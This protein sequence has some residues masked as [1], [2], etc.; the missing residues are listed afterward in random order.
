MSNKGTQ[1]RVGSKFAVVYPDFPTFN[2]MPHHMRLHQEIGKQDVVELSYTNFNQFYQ[3]GLKTGV[4]VKIDWSN[5]KVSG[6][7]T[8]YVMDVTPVVQQALYNPTIVRCIGAS[9]SLKEGG[10]KIWVS[11]TAAQIVTEIAKKFKLKPVVTEDGLIFSQQ[12]L[13]GHT[14]WEKIQELASRKGYVSQVFGTELHFHPL[15]KMIDLAMTVIPVFSFSEPFTSPWANVMS[16]TLDQFKPTG[17]DYFSHANNRRTEKVITVIDPLT[18]K[19][20]THSNKA[21]SVG[22]KL[23]T[24]TKDPLFAETL[25]KVITG[26]IKMAQALAESHAQLSR[27][28]IHAEGKGQGDPRVAPY[29]TIEINGTGESTDGFW[30]IK[31]VTHFLA[32]DGR[33]QIEFSCMTDGTGR[34]QASASRPSQA[35]TVPVRN[36]NYETTTGTTVKST[37]VKLNAV[38]PLISQTNAGWKVTPRRWEGR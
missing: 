27:F 22:K 34:N 30:V 26:N 37:S 35:G 10:H 24:N 31:K 3:K 16:Q 28:S 36:L 7:F 25:P 32:V 29:R 23:R 14:H 12:S 4:P 20:T 1:D 8:G 2:A 38:S 18:G 9:L 17:G 11:K 21:N 13:T 5:D 6:T 33:Y 19:L 15:D